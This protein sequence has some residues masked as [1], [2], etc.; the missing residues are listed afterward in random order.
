MSVIQDWLNNLRGKTNK[1]KPAAP[2]FP[3]VNVNGKMV[4][5]G[6]ISQYNPGPLQRLE[7]VPNQIARGL[8]DKT[9]TSF[10]KPGNI[11]YNAANIVPK[12]INKNITSPLGKFLL[13]KKGDEQSGIVGDLPPKPTGK[14]ESLLGGAQAAFNA[15]PVGVGFNAASAL[16][17]GSAEKRTNP[18][19]NQLNQTVKNFESG[20]SNI[21]KALNIKNPIASAAANL[22]FPF[23][24]GSE[25]K[26][27]PEEAASSLKTIINQ[28]SKIKSLE[29]WH[30][31]ENT[32]LKQF[33]ISMHS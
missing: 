21:G 11:A 16:A 2:S 14:L 30:C 27:N 5:G 8:A 29:D 20:N 6:T 26:I 23:V 3:M 12:Y 32:H 7:E 33:L 15:T 13:P 31:S 17:M 28:I 24:I 18:N 10:N 9:N 25:G 1:P 19:V 4:P 22:A